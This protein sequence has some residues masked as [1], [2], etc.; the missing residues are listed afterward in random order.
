M[1]RCKAL[2]EPEARKSLTHEECHRLV[3]TSHPVYL[4][5]AWR[6]RREQN[7][8]LIHNSSCVACFCCQG[9]DLRGAWTAMTA[10]RPATGRFNAAHGC[11]QRLGA[12]SGAAGEH[13][14]QIG[15]SGCNQPGPKALSGDKNK[16]KV[17]RATCVVRWV[18][19]SAPGNNS[20]ALGADFAT[21]DEGCSMSKAKR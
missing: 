13:L 21:T 5:S 7:D 18:R 8:S 20:S 9:T 4:R 16:N 3:R 19:R 15:L 2:S 12:G 6:A 14:A 17:S 1:H 10:P 11:P